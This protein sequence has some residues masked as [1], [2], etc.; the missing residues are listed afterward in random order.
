SEAAGER[1]PY[2]LS[3]EDAVRALKLYR[4]AVASTRDLASERGKMTEATLD[5]NALRGVEPAKIAAR[6]V[7][8]M[9]PLA[10][11]IARRSGAPGELVLRKNVGAGRRDEVY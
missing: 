5:G 8:A 6:M 2:E 10:R 9:A 3:S 1:E 7:H 4:A 11:E